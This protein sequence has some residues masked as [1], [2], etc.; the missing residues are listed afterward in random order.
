MKKK[1]LM[2]PLMLMLM[3][4]LALTSTAAGLPINDEYFINIAIGDNENITFAG[5]TDSET[6]GNWIV[7]KGGTSI[8]LP[9]PLTFGY[10]GINS[11]TFVS[12]GKTISVTAN[13]ENNTDYIVEYPYDKHPMFTNVTGK[14]DL[15]IDFY[16][17]NYFAGKGVDVYLIRTSPSNLKNAVDDLSKGDSSYF[18][19]LG[20]SSYATSLNKLL[21]NK[22][23]FKSMSFGKLDAGDYVIIILQN[24]S[25]LP[26]ANDLSIL[27]ATAFEVLEYDSIM[28]APNNAAPDSTVI[29]SM[30]LTD[31]SVGSYT[32]GAILVHES[33]Y[34]AAIML[35]SNGTKLG[36]DLL[37][38]G[39][40]LIKGFKVSGVGSSNF[41]SA[42][43]TDIINDVI[44]ANDGV[45]T[46][47]TTDSNSTSILLDTDG[48]RRV[49]YVL[50][51]GVY[52]SGDNLVAF[53]QSDVTL[54]SGTPPSPPSSNRRN[55][56]V[57]VNF[58]A[59]LNDS[60]EGNEEAF[61]SV[62]ER[63]PVEYEPDVEQ[64]TTEFQ[65]TEPN[66]SGSLWGF[67]SKIWHSFLNLFG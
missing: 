49:N 2:L 45:V 31:A 64:P 11:T 21:D 10:H 65:T 9:S 53:G 59:E 35:E 58:N 27:S 51:V 55:N 32:Y 47:K 3:L 28:S 42:D 30:S 24:T 41:D 14:N 29:V 7:L 56:R 46:F 18:R 52:K 61:M 54:S 50:L 36:T 12:N 39:A 40:D 23:D 15:V 48:L 19:N 1:M 16:G 33:A 34:K 43:A 67:L 62:P 66:L 22:G 4:I 44:G 17:S 63:Q 13:M 38:N 60:E 57:N 5:H 6:E 26:G 37:M 20:S 8:K 25:Y